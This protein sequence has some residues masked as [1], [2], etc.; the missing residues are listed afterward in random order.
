MDQA[1]STKAFQYASR[2]IFVMAAEK[3]AAQHICP[4]GAH[5]RLDARII[6]ILPL[7]IRIVFAVDIMIIDLAYFYIRINPYRLYTENF[8]CPVTGEPYIAEPGRDVD[9]HTQPAHRRPTF[10]H[11]FQWTPS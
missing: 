11:G 5:A 4:G 3:E 1:G 2:Q 9:E 6:L 10:Q 8:Q 7:L